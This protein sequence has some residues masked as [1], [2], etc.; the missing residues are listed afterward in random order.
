[1]RHRALEM[2]FATAK[3]S[4]I[5]RNATLFKDCLICDTATH[6]DSMQRPSTSSAKAYSGKGRAD[7]APVQSHRYTLQT[8]NPFKQ[9]QRT[10]QD[11]SDSPVQTL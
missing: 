4:G 10:F 9:K 2:Y 7:G 8:N 6:E 5:L 3:S 1:M 11:F